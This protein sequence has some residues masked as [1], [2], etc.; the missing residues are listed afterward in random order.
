MMIGFTDLV[1]KNM[2]PVAIVLVAALFSVMFIWII[3]QNNRKISRTHAKWLCA[4]TL[5]S[6]SSLFALC[7]VYGVC[8]W[9]DIIKLGVYHTAT[10]IFLFFF[11]MAFCVIVILFYKML[12]QKLREEMKKIA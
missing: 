1:H 10:V 8:T 12:I 6:I 4:Y 9:I 2:F 7:I 3:F 11:D 5:F